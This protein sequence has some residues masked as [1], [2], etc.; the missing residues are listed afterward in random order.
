VR[1]ESRR[2]RRHAAAIHA[3]TN[4]IL[5]TVEEVI[6]HALQV[7]GFALRAPVA[8]RSRMRNGR[9]TGLEIVVRLQDPRRADAAMAALFERYPDPLSDVIVG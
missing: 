1:A 9:S 3:E 6:A 4:A 5:D 7:R 2:A 8:A